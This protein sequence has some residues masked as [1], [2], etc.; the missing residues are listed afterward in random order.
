MWKDDNVDDRIDKRARKGYE[1]SKQNG[2]RVCKSIYVGSRERDIRNL[3]GKRIMNRRGFVFG[4]IFGGVAG[5]FAKRK[6]TGSTR[7]TNAV[8][9][10]KDRSQG[11]DSRQDAVGLRPEFVFDEQVIADFEKTNEKIEIGS[12]VYL[13]NNGT[14]TVDPQGENDP[15]GIALE[16]RQESEEFIRIH[17]ILQVKSCTDGTSF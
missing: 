5:M 4:S 17:V 3:D 15:L 11:H 14:V 16:S 8:A 6:R 13:H 2:S 12:P 9:V 10:W 7:E 1:E